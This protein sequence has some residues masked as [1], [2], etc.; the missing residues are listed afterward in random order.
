MSEESTS[1]PAPGRLNRLRNWLSLAGMVLCVSAVFAF[2]LLVAVDLFATHANPYM[3]ILAYVVA[4]MFF[5][6]GLGL[7]ILG[8]ILE[9]RR[10]RKG[11]PR[12][13]GALVL[14]VDLSRKRDRQ[15]MAAFVLGSIG[16]LLLT[17]FGSYET[18]HLMETNSFCGQACHTPMEPQF[19]AHQHSSHAQV[20]CVACHIGPGTTAY[21]RTKL[22]GVKQLY[23]QIR[24]D[25][26][27]PIRILNPNLR[28]AQ[29]TCQ[30]CHWSE[31]HF[32]DVPK[33]FRR[34]LADE[35][36]TPFTVQMLLKVGGSDPVRGPVE[37][38]HSHMNVSNK[39]EFIHLDE[40]RLEIPWVRVTDAD[41][42]VTEYRTE[43][44]TD[45]ISK[46]QIRTMD[47][48]DCHNRPAHKFLPPNDAVDQ[49]LAMGRIDP[50]IPWAKKNVVTAL[51]APYSNR[52]E[53]QRKIGEFLRAEYPDDKR[54]DALIA[55]A[56][57]LYSTNFFPEMKADWRAHP[58]QIGHKDTNGCFRCHAGN[59]FN[60]DRSRTIKGSDCNACHIITA[61]GAGEELEK[62]N[63]K[64]HDFFHVDS[65][66]LEPNCAECH[67]GQIQEE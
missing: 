61:Q 39:I 64:G 48:M 52:E 40:E 10:I 50:S 25:F 63:L 15:L 7:V 14:R 55:E 54:A 31:K 12:K 17:A 23:H 6:M 16:F 33:T 11:V 22:N 45:D 42:K 47:C 5:F 44:F 34:F 41:G 21:I 18:Y 29:E 49:A 24:G 46:H 43:E 37:G 1:T 30:T 19:S 8:Y 51:A 59:H 3:G 4:P 28:L 67:N 56:R 32:G 53:A 26:N 57:K 36:N 20:D 60:E 38:I 58:D 62:V 9:T 2:I 66:Y 65:D 35:E 13:E 27:R